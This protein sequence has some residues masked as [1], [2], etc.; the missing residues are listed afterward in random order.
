MRSRAQSR[1]GGSAVV[2]EERENLVHESRRCERIGT[3]EKGAL[4]RTYVSHTRRPSASPF[5]WVIRIYW[6]DTNNF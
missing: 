2:G 5:V 4:R 3:W 1:T 6:D